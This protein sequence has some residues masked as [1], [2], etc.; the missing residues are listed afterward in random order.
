MKKEPGLLAVAPRPTKKRSLQEFQ[1]EETGAFGGDD[2]GF[3]EEGD[4]AEE[5]DT[6]EHVPDMPSVHELI[7]AVL[8]APAGRTRRKVR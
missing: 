1:S 7:S 8:D 2:Q 6:E 3:A 5:E 4:A